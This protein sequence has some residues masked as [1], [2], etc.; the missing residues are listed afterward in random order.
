LIY[1]LYGIALKCLYVV[2]ALMIC[3]SLLFHCYAT[4]LL[5]NNVEIMVVYTGSCHI[6]IMGEARS[7][8][9]FEPDIDD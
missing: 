7:K 9:G 3:L 2:K 5:L 4:A 8:K 6:D 1:A